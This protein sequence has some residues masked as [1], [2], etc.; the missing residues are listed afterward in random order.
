M[1]AMNDPSADG[2][3]MKIYRREK[4]VKKGIR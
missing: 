2:K 4:Y 1:K 3:Q